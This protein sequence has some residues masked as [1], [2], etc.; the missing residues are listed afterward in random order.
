MSRASRN[1]TRTRQRAEQK[2]ARRRTRNLARIPNEIREWAKNTLGAFEAKGIAPGAVMPKAPT[3]D[4]KL[5]RILFVHQQGIQ[6]C[7]CGE[8]EVDAEA[9]YTVLNTPELKWLSASCSDCHNSRV[10][11]GAASPQQGEGGSVH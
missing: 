5:W 11:S 4:N 1:M 9:R 10:A 6:C 7:E 3:V 8:V 2:V